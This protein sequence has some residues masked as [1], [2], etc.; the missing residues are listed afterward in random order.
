MPK[1]ETISGRDFISAVA[2][3]V[4]TILASCSNNYTNCNSATST[5][6]DPREVWVQFARISSN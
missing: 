3:G 5:S 6:M 1:L 4:S 2:L